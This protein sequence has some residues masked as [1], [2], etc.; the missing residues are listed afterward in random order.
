MDIA[1]DD[2]DQRGRR[3][4]KREANRKLNDN[5]KVEGGGE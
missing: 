5:D 1:N 3:R 2:D 4:I